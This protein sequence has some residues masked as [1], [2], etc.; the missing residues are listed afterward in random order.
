MTDIMHHGKYQVKVQRPL[1]A[2]KQHQTWLVY[3][4][5]KQGLQRIPADQIPPNVKSAMGAD[6][7]AYFQS[8]W[9]GSSGWSIGERVKDKTW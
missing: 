5:G 7:K 9:A 4:K 3:A 2:S 8:M 6:F 1:G